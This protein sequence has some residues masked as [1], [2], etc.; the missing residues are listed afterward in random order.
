MDQ[1]HRPDVERRGHDHSRPAGGQ[2]FGELQPGIT[3]IEAAVN[4]GRLDVEQSFRAVDAGH[5]HQ[6]A[7]RHLRRRAHF[8]RQQ[9]LVALSQDQVFIVHLT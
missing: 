8:A 4:M 1:V 9:C 3:V 7:H 6:D 5:G 2:S